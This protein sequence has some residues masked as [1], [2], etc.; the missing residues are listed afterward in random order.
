MTYSPCLGKLDPSLCLRDN[1]PLASLTV[2]CSRDY[3]SLF[4]GLIHSA[5]LLDIHC[6]N[7]PLIAPDS[8]LLTQVEK[9]I[10]LTWVFF[11]LS[12][13]TLDFIGFF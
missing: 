9:L 8:C 7:G 3:L 2:G 1:H 6:L 10:F 13:E 5:H 4:R 12:A 11:V